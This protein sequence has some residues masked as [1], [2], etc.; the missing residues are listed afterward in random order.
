MTRKNIGI[1]FHVQVFWMSS[2]ETLKALSK[3]LQEI[4]PVLWPLSL[5]QDSF[6]IFVYETEN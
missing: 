2:Q 6:Y 4:K 1:I 5:T 3:L